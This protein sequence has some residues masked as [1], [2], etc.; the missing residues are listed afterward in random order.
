M[1]FLDD[2]RV[3]L[4]QLGVDLRRTGEA[5]VLHESI[6][7]KAQEEGG[8]GNIGRLFGLLFIY[9]YINRY[10]GREKP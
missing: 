10:S 2:K 1:M 5:S 6:P 4:W 3:A 9:T 8:G 7:E